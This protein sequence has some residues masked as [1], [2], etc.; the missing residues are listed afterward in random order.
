MAND[1]KTSGIDSSSRTE[2][3]R[4]MERGS[5]TDEKGYGQRGSKDLAEKASDAG[6][7]IAEKASDAGE[8]LAE[9]AKSAG[10]AVMESGEDFADRAKGVHSTICKFTKDN[11]T[12]SVLIAFGAGAVLARLLPKW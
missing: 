6:D 12:A 1:M 3:Q 8:T 4:T 9:K 7:K 11:P 5:L 10:H 2:H